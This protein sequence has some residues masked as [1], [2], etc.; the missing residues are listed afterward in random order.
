M[1]AIASLDDPRVADY[2][3]IT[4]PALLARAGLLVAEGRLVLRRLVDQPRFRIR[5]VLLTDTARVALDPVVSRLGPEVPAYVT[6][7]AAM[8]ALAGFEIH[9]GCL[10]LAERPP[11]TPVEELDLTTARRLVILEGVNNP[12][13]VGGVFRSAAA[14]GVDAILL[15]P[16]CGDPLYR[17]AIRTSMAATLQVPFAAALPWPQTLETIGARG[18][19]VLGLTPAI[20]ARPLDE[21][22][23]NVERVALVL[24]AEGHGLTEQ[25]LAAVHERVRIPMSGSA[26]SLNVTV[27]ASIA[28]WH[29]SGS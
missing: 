28:L 22:A 29:F 7:Q 26:D 1:I 13:N 12:D 10:A 23:R 8:S 16:E 15:G 4:R 11:L 19:R 9:R 5:S 20:D 17:K 24:G 6:S 3:L 27:A 2:R 18:F 25:A 21:Y 14:F